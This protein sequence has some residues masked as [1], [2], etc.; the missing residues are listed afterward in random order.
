MGI[1][2]K[3]IK[4]QEA[5]KEIKDMSICQK[6]GSKMVDNTFKHGSRLGG[7]YNCHCGFYI[8]F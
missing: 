4:E 8:M 2:D 1:L 7:S 3:I 6:C 5:K